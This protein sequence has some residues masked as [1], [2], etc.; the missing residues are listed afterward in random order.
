MHLCSWG[1]THAQHA[2]KTT[3]KGILRIGMSHRTA[4]ITNSNQI[5]QGHKC[6][7]CG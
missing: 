5:Q 4:A 2:Y 7:S 1:V 3:G 6:T